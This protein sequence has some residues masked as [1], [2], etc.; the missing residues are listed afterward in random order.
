[1]VCSPLAKYVVEKYD[2]HCLGREV[3]VD[4]V[5]VNPFTGFVRLQ[6]PKVKELNNDTIFFSSNSVDA[7]FALL[8][9]FFSTYEIT[10]LDIDKPVGFII[11]NNKDLNFNDIIER[12]RPQKSNGT[13]TRFSVRKVSITGGEFHY[14]EKIIPI[15]YFIKNVNLESSGILWIL[16]PSHRYTHLRQE[17]VR[18]L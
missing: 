2:I 18:E 7:D 16:I 15:D 1:M 11:Q 4:W 6:G 8:K 9:M 3:T 13:K 12:F 14:R 5:Y 10:A 17:R